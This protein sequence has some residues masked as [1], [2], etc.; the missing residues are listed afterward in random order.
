MMGVVF[1]AFSLRGM[2]MRC[3]SRSGASWFNVQ[4]FQP[5]SLKGSYTKARVAA[6]ELSLKG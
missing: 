3:S 6:V 2:S 5:Q 1:Q 4:G